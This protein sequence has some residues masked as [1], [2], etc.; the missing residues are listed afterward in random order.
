M[1]AL[2]FQQ[3]ADRAVRQGFGRYGNHSPTSL[4]WFTLS[5]YFVALLR[6][7]APGKSG[8][9]TAFI[10]A[11]GVNADAIKSPATGLALE[12]L[13]VNE[14]AM[15]LAGAWRILEAGPEGLIVATKAASIS[16]SALR[17]RCQPLP[18]CIADIIRQLPDINYSRTG[19]SRSLNEVPEPHP[20]Q[21][22]MRMF[23]RLQRKVQVAVR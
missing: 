2:A 9:L 22:V 3:A 17:E 8:S 23:A 13:P 20:H 18:S 15:L 21:V 12:L 10:T 7:V 14:R 4:E 6:K 11:L 5:R 16:A 19:R 1:D